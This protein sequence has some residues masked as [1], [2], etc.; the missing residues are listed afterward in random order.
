[1]DGKKYFRL[2]PG[3]LLEHPVW[4]LAMDVA[5]FGGAEEGDWDDDPGMVVPLPR[6]P[7]LARQ[8]LENCSCY[9]RARFV[10]ANGRSFLG[11]MKCW[12]GDTVY[13]HTE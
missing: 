6:D 10:A 2:T 13:M 8:L 12:S 4:V 9:A 3:D 1:M 11:M 5:T 7:T